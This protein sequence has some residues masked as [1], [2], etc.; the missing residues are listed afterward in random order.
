MARLWI[1]LRD[2]HESFTKK[3]IEYIIDKMPYL[4]EE[5][6]NVFRKT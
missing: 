4:K 2:H 6:E 3:M 1:F 5:P